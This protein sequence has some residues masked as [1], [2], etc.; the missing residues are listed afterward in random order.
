MRAGLKERN[1]MSVFEEDIRF[2]RA[3]TGDIFFFS[4][5]AYLHD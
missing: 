2:F 5:A 3:A 1:G 4:F